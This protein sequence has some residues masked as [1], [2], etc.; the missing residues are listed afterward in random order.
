[1]SDIVKYYQTIPELGIY[2]RMNTPEEFDKIALPED[3]KG[4]SV[5]DIG[6]NIGAFMVECIKR[7]ANGCAGIEPNREWRM[8]ANGVI[9][10]LGLEQCAVFGSIENSDPEMDLVLLLSI[11][12]LVDD[13]QFI[14]DTAWKH[15]GKLMILEVNDRLQTIPFSMPNAREIKRI[16]K[17]KDNRSVYHLWK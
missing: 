7:G 5:L 13:P 6:C 15:T 2:G 3:L 1:M 11:S 16:G 12:H 4:W 17:N 8:I 10:E 14:I 9:A